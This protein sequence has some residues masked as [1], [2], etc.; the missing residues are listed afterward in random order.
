MPRHAPT[1]DIVNQMDKFYA[2]YRNTPV[3]M[4]TPVQ[5]SIV[6]LRGRVSSEQELELERKG[7]QP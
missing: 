5:E 6:S 2:D 7:C 4:I 1:L 3:S